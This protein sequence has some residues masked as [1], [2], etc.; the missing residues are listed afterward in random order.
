MFEITSPTISLTYEVPSLNHVL[1]CHV[2][3][4]QLPPETGTLALPWEH[5]NV[6][7]MLP[8]ALAG[9]Q[10]VGLLLDCS[11]RTSPTASLHLRV[12]GHSAGT[13]MGLQWADCGYSVPEV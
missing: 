10:S 12:L 9:D 1:Q 2:H 4:S 13:C 11:E 8:L 6:R 7:D 3:I 5:S